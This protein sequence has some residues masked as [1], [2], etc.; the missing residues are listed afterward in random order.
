MAT[1]VAL[2]LRGFLELCDTGLTVS[3][4]LARL[5]SRS[6]AAPGSWLPDGYAGG[7]AGACVTLAKH[8][9]YRAEIADSYRPKRI[10]RKKIE[11]YLPMCALLRE[12]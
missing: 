5:C 9:G 10:P 4:C 6:V 12:V 1:L 2:L 8:R 3:G 11:I 7:A